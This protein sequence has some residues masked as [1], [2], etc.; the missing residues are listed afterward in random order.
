LSDCIHTILAEFVAQFKS[1]IL[2][3]PN[4]TVL[5]TGIPIDVNVYESEHKVTDEEMLKILAE[6]PNLVSGGSS[7]S[8]N[9]KKKKKS[10]GNAGGDNKENKSESE[11]N[12]EK[13]A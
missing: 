8:K 9:K 12:D 13:K 6:N 7:S 4:G 11:G 2:L 5:C 10:S 3:L 1:T